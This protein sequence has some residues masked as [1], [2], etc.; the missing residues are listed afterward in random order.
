MPTVKNCLQTQLL[1]RRAVRSLRPRF[2][3]ATS[4]GDSAQRAAKSKPFRMGRLSFQFCRTYPGPSAEDAARRKPA[5]EEDNGAE[6]QSWRNDCQAGL[7]QGK[8]AGTAQWTYQNGTSLQE[9]QAVEAALAWQGWPGAKRTSPWS[10]SPPISPS[11]FPI[12][13]SHV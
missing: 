1:R 11:L 5:E 6:K 8:C 2:F 13:F 3:G 12:L 9:D 10:Q 4:S 7:S